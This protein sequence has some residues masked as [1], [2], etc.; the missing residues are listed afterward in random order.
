V[1]HY[2]EDWSVEET[3]RALGIFP[4]TVKS[5]LH[6]ARARLADALK[7]SEEGIRYDA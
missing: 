2:F 5:R 4:G 7:G 1:F 6:K 3:A